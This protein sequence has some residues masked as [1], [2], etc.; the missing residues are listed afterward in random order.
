MKDCFNYWCWIW[1]NPSNSKARSMGFDVVAID[2]N[3]DAIGMPL[4]TYSYPID[5]LDVRSY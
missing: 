2:K 4:A 3:P 1:P 5:V